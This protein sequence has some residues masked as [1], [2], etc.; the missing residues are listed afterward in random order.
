M[1]PLP[2]QVVRG[3]NR[4]ALRGQVFFGPQATADLLAELGL[5]VAGTWSVTETHGEEGYCL[6]VGDEGLTVEGGEAG[7][8]WAVQTLRQL[9]H[10]Q[11]ETL[12]YMDMVDAPRYPWRG[13]LL[14][15]ARWCLPIEFLYRYVDL[16]ALHK[17]NRL[18]LHLTDDQGWRFEVKRYPRLTE[19]GGFRRES[20]LG[21][22][23]ERKWDGKPHGGFYTQEQL[24]DLVAFGRRRGVEI[25]PEIDLPGH[26]QAAI[27]AYPELG[28]NP[29]RQVEV[30]TR[31]GI[32]DIVL[33]TEEST[34]DFFKAVLDEVVDVFPF[35]YVH[36]GGDEVRSR[37]WR[38]HPA[39]QARAKELGLSDVDDML[40]WWIGRLQSHL[41]GHGRMV[42]VWDELLETNPPKDLLFFGWRDSA[43]APAAREAGYEAVSCPQEHAYFDWAESDRSDEP[44]AIRGYLP[45]DKA[46]AFEPGDVTG[47]QG[48]LW[49]EYLPTPELVEW[50][51]FPRLAALAEIGWGKA[52]YIDFSRRLPNHL[53]LLRELGV[54]YRPR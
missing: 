43:K 24:K 11:G 18:H 36:L 45:L 37:E 15:V 13:S 41:A 52:D 31:W 38:D 35:S 53:E 42:A 14:D 28:N 10:E 33:N 12:S 50:R 40:G 5:P 4:V 54:H 47:V 26:T 39:V 44:L 7:L 8:K 16:L 3:S 9:I 22:Y 6:R 48:N 2:S 46:Y 20:V 30:S 23:S 17:L 21:H 19:V 34:V 32:H 51:A 1:I 29:S 25:M 49:T 27:A